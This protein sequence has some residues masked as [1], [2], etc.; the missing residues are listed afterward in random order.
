MLDFIDRHFPAIIVSVFVLPLI[1]I[2]ISDAFRE[3]D[4]AALDASYAKDV[5]ESIVTVSPRPGVECYVLRGHSTYNTRA[6]SCVVLP[7]TVQ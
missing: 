6:M 2:T 5:D 4:K 1:A 7:E 3:T